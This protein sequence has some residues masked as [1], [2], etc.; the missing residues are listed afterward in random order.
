[1]LIKNSAV[2]LV[3]WLHLIMDALLPQFPFEGLA[4]DLSC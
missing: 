2:I 1:M 3:M 4:Y